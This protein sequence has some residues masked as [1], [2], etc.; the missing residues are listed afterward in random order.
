VLDDAH[1]VAGELRR[2]SARF[3]IGDDAVATHVEHGVRYRFDASR[4]MFSSGNVEERARMARIDAR[5]E[6]V[7]DMFAGIGYFA[8]PLARAGAARVHACEK[9]PDAF[10]WLEQNARLNGVADALRLWLGDD[11]ALPLDGQ[12]DRVVMGYFPRTERYLPKAFTLLK[13]GG[14]VVHY[15]NTA[16]ADGWRAEL[17]A[18][19]AA[20]AGARA[21]R[22]ERARVVKT[23]SP[24]VVHAVLDLRVGPRDREIA[25][26]ARDVGRSSV[27]PW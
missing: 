13:P 8:V 9:N 10:V 5:G 16:R 12:A 20:T 22:V 1:G 6:T 19:V 14:G 11:R 15:H 25:T 21:W 24:G 23:H 26:V 2:P 18:Q 4:V 27:S 3:L 7:I 17:E